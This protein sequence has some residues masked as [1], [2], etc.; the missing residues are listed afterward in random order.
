M[1]YGL[2]CAISLCRAQ[3]IIA[4]STETWENIHYVNYSS[5]SHRTHALNQTR[6]SKPRTGSSTLFV[7]QAL[8]SL[9]F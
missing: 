4:V 5:T 6:G 7:P 9:P 2:R 8:Y 3:S 1:R